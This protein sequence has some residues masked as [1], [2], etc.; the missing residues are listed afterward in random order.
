MTSNIFIN[1]SLHF[2]DEF[3]GTYSCD[4]LP[5][6]INSKLTKYFVVNLDLSTGVGTHFIFLELGSKHALYWDPLGV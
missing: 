4:D 3:K 1:E 5:Q 6:I 2:L